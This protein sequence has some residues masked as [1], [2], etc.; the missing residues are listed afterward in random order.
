MTNYR[1]LEPVE[2][3]GDG[4]GMNK[5]YTRKNLLDGQVEGQVKAIFDMMLDDGFGVKDIAYSIIDNTM[6]H[7]SMLRILGK[8]Q[9]EPD[10]SI[11]EDS[12]K[13]LLNGGV[14]YK[15]EAIKLYRRMKN[16][17]LAEAKA[18]I[19]SMMAEVVLSWQMEDD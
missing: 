11:T 3:V 18:D 9:L 12:I 7:S 16:V 6:I 8:K 1:P 13:E 17:G 19:D 4:H 5:D 10:T 15:F 14:E 2:P